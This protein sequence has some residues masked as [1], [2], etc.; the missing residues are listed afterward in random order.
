VSEPEVIEL[1]LCEP[2]HLFLRPDVLYRFV[3]MEGCPDCARACNPTGIDGEGFQ[4][5]P[6]PIEEVGAVGKFRAFKHYGDIV[7]TDDG[8]GVAHTKSTRQA[9][10]IMRALANPTALTAAPEEE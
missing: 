8:I 1:A 7:I 9:I 2:P 3:V 4:T 6:H 10:R 5:T